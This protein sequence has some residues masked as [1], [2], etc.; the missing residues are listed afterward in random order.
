M[1]WAVNNITLRGGL[2]IIMEGDSDIR[3]ADSDMVGGRKQK[4]SDGECK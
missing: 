1:R 2:E 3:N 4:K